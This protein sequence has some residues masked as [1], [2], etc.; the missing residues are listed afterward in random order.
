[1][2]NQR[3]GSSVDFGQFWHSP[4]FISVFVVQSR[5]NKNYFTR[6]FSMVI[7]HMSLVNRKPAFCICENKDADQ[8]LRF[9]FFESTILLLPKSEI[10][11]L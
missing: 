4:T 11:S 2:T 8:R 10:S 5:G 7:H 9:R 3:I 1:M 6:V